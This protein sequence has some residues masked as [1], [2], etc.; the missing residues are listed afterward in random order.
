MSQSKITIGIPRALLYHKYGDL[1]EQ[2]FIN[3]HLNVIVSPLT[4]KEILSEGLSRTID[5]NCLPMKIFLGHVHYLNGRVTH[6]FI[7]RITSLQKKKKT[8]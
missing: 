2:F 6:L 7:P 5:E 4:N 8:A 3:L 1:W